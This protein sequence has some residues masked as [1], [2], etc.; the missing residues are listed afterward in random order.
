MTLKLFKVNLLIFLIALMSAL[1]SA[2]AAVDKPN[3]RRIGG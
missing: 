2:Q 3:R 1:N